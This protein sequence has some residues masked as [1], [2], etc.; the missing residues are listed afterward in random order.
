MKNIFLHP[1]HPKPVTRRDFLRTGIIQF[2]ATLAAP[3]LL[4]QLFLANK[5][6]AQCASKEAVSDLIPFL[7]FDMAGGAGL[8]GNFLVGKNGEPE[9]LLASYDKLGWDPRTSGALDKSF[10]LPMAG[11]NISQIL[12]GIRQGA[13]AEALQNLRMGSFCNFSG[14]DRTTNPLSALTLV[15]KVGYKG[16]LLPNGLGSRNSAAG[17]NSDPALPDLTLKP[18]FVSKVEDIGKSLSYGTAFEGFSDNELKA[19]GKTIH[20]MSAEQ[21]A[22]FSQMDQGKQLAELAECTYSQN[23]EYGAQMSGVDPRQDQAFQRIYNVN[24][25]TATTDES[26]ISAAVVMNVLKQNSGPGALTI[27]ECD[28][29]NRGQQFTDGKDREAGLQIGRAVE[30]AF[31]LNR[32]L[33]F[34]LITDGGVYANP[35][36]REWQGDDGT[37]SLTVIGFFDP[38]SP[39]QQRRLQ[40]GQYGDGQAVDQTTLIGGEP[41]KAAYAV[42]A[43]YL[44]ACGK[45]GDF[46]KVAPRG[47][48]NTQQMD[49][50]L[51]FG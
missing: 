43:N 18:L 5:A 27:G 4:S 9:N 10:G 51:I 50:I 24:A 30:A 45:L 7:V 34:Q 47:F 42:F 31:R 22:Q 40:V 23:E 12:A 37:K 13:S 39:P 11:N 35:N 49:E 48:F 21:A 38:K 28:Y 6:R 46:E 32:P 41:A 29:H 17:G 25:G 8:P 20:N 14:D 16:R 1:D 33:F 2:S 19:L 15:S 3:T 44:N 36:T 26:A